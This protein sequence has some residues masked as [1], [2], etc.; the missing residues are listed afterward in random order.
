M[1]L[2]RFQVLQ[3]K[4]KGAWK[5]LRAENIPLL[6]E[7]LI[8][9]TRPEALKISKL[10]I[11]FVLAAKIVQKSSRIQKV[12]SIINIKERKREREIKWNPFDFELMQLRL[13]YE[14]RTKHQRDHLSNEFDG[15]VD[16]NSYGLFK[17]RPCK[18]E[19]CGCTVQSRKF[20]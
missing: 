2:E 13:D 20:W 16:Y 9:G 8:R 11:T 12:F 6:R 14:N 19:I 1:F 3:R 5:L 18:R 10:L 7:A 4:Q 15:Y 17:T